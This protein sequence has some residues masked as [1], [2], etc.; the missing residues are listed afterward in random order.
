MPEKFCDGQEC[1]DALNEYDNQRGEL[2]R[3]CNAVATTWSKLKQ[4]SF[5][6]F[7]GIGI[8]S[9]GIAATYQTFS[10]TLTLVGFWGIIVGGI[11]A[12]GSG[13]FV[14]IWAKDYNQRMSKCSKKIDEVVKAW[15][16]VRNACPRERHPD[17]KIC[18][19]TG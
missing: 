6:T 9:L 1:N 7:G 14:L 18:S 13:I 4:W 5:L 2:V 16:K 3:I 19:C 17:L 11:I 8:L 15:N 12:C 10:N